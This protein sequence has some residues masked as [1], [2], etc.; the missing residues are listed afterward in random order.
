MP[1]VAVVTDSTSS[2]APRQAERADVRVIPLQVVID[3]RSR[4]EGEVD[5][6]EVAAA[7][8]AG[9]RVSTSRPTPEVVAAAYAELAAGGCTGVVSVHLSGGI[10]GTAQAAE[11]AARGASVPVRVVDS[12]GAAMATGFAALAAAG[13]A[14]DG[15]DLDAVAAAASRR[16]AATSTWFCVDDLV[17]LRRGGRV[18]AATAVLGTA[19]A[20]K[21]LLTVADGAIRPF[22]R[23]RTSARALSRLEQL[24][25]GAVRAG[26]DAGHVVDVAVHH[27]DNAAAA[28]RLADALREQRPGGSVLVSELSA[29]LAVHV[30]PGTVGV[31]VSPAV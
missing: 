23:V 30:G 5:A 16:A 11:V 26:V 7:L 24:A 20:V 4:P 25:A 6:A 8:R 12:R 29:V 14:R 17:H 9:R 28:E 1:G 13:S 2:F 15:G 27:L 18:S 3:G 22:E 31:V 10:S 19:L 21:P